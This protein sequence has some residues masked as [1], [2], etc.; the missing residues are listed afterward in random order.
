[1]IGLYRP[2]THDVL[3]ITRCPL[4]DS[5]IAR[6]LD[7]LPDAIVRERV[8]IHGAT[9]RGLRYVLL[10]AS[11]A[12]RRLLV[13][14]VTSRT[15]LLAAPALARRLRAA[16]PLAGL[17]VN[18]NASAGNVIV[19]QRTSRVW[20]APELR[21]RYGDVELT[22]SPLAFVQANTRMA[23]AIYRTIAASAALRG[24]ERVLDLYCGVG[25][26]ALTLA[27]DAARVVGVEEVEAAV[28][29][30]RA[31]ARRNGRGN[32]RFEVGRVEEHVRLTGCGRTSSR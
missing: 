1:M 30:A 19:G 10:R 6:A 26:I 5:L 2:G 7:V 4:H 3:D 14:L 18:E 12:D 13:T 23:A 9:R 21:D 22:A 16:L 27:R 31:N 17:L 15:P 20:G 28:R 29:A 8:P 24:G 25:G 32:V 11:V